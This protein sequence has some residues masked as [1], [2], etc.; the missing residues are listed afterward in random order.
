MDQNKKMVNQE[1]FLRQRINKAQEQLKKQKK[2]NR[3]KDVR[4]MFQSLTG[5]SL[6]ELTMSDLTDL[7]WVIDQHLKEIQLRVKNINNKA[8]ES[9]NHVQGA[10]GLPATRENRMPAM[11]TNSEGSNNNTAM[12][13]D[14]EGSIMQHATLDMQAFD[15]MQNMEAMQPQMMQMVTQKPQNSWFMDMMNAPAPPPHQDHHKHMGF[16]EEMM[17]PF[18]D[19]D[20]STMW[21]NPPVGGNNFP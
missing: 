20:N 16:R 3:E 11:K 13:S 9:R 17:F 4:V 12:K 15:Q 2:D 18:A 21:P 10:Q 6:Q 8:M 19:H 1:S 14:E 7:N 5:K